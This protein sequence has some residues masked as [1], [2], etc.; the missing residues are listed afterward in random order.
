[1]RKKW[2]RCTNKQAYHRPCVSHTYKDFITL[3]FRRFY[4]LWGWKNVW[5]CYLLWI[6]HL[7]ITN[8]QLPNLWDM[9]S[10]D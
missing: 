4:F 1:M 9:L 5:Y 2:I 6:K 10:T 8:P 7:R 3:R